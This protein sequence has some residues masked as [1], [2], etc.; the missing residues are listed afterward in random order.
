VLS[1]LL[2]AA[3]QLQAR[4]FDVQFPKNTTMGA[5]VLNRDATVYFRSA[6]QVVRNNFAD[7]K[8]QKDP[9]KLLLLRTNPITAISG[10]RAQGFPNPP[11]RMVNSGGRFPENFGDAIGENTLLAYVGMGPLNESGGGVA[12]VEIH[13]DARG[14]HPNLEWYLPLKQ[15]TLALAARIV[16]DTTCRAWTL[17]PKIGRWRL[18]ETDV[19]RLR[20]SAKA[21]IRFVKN[22]SFPTLSRIWYLPESDRFIYLDRN[23]VYSLTTG[24]GRVLHTVRQLESKDGKSLKRYPIT[25]AFWD[26][27]VD[28]AAVPQGK[29]AWAPLASTP[30]G[31]TWL[32]TSVATGEAKLLK[33]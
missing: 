32:A 24:R 16:S 19:D 33:F 4:I 8:S 3:V 9:V 14:P 21:R 28:D 15:H 22:I 30:D 1:I 17:E 2:A 10:T 11:W 20:P 31:K 12:L 7:G 5:G 23:D 29:D 18:M 26:L 6:S 25:Q 27:L 13:F